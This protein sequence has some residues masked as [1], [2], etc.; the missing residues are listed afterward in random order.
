[1]ASTETVRVSGVFPPS[2]SLR[3]VE[4]YFYLS[5]SL[6]IAAVVIYGFG[7]T[8]QRKLIQATPPRPILLWVH[9]FLFC[10]WVAFYIAQSILVR[11]HKV[12]LHGSLGWAG[13]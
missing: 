6:L 3:W 5:M 11:V 13:A 7:H 2:V 9:A 4:R 12:K 1:M 8:V 10:A